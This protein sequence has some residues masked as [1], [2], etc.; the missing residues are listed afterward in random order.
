MIINLILCGG[1]ILALK[2]PGQWD[3]LPVKLELIC[4]YWAD[5]ASAGLLAHGLTT[6]LE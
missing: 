1:K 3:F 2:S 5:D 4:G 6:L